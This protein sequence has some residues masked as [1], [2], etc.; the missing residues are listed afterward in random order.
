MSALLAPAGRVDRYAGLSDRLGPARLTRIENPDLLNIE[1]SEGALERRY[2]F[3]REHDNM[4]RV[5]STRLNGVNNYVRIPHHPTYVSTGKALYVGLLVVIREIPTVTTTVWS[6]GFGIGAGLQFALRINPT[7]GA[8]GVL[9]WECLV[10]NGGATTTFAVDETQPN[11]AP[12]GRHRFLQF[13]STNGL[14]S[15]SEFAF[16][17]EAGNKST[18]LTT[19]AIGGVFNSPDDLFL[20]VDCPTTANIAGGNFA[21]VT[22]A[23]AR[24]AYYT[25]LSEINNGVFTI[26]HTAGSGTGL[27]QLI[28]SREL[29]PAE[30]LLCE[31]YWKL[32]DADT[33]NKF[34]D[35]TATNN[36][37]YAPDSAYAWTQDQGLVLGQ[38][39]IRFLGGNSWLHL[40]DGSAGT[41]ILNGVF[42][43]ALPNNARWTVRFIYAPELAPNETSA[44]D[45]C[46]LWAGTGTTLPTP[47]GIRVVSDRF[48]LIYNDGTTPITL[49]LNGAGDPLVSSLANKK[50]RIAAIKSATGT[51]II[52]L[53]I[54]YYSG[55]FGVPLGYTVKN[56]SAACA[57]NTS[58][59]SPD[60]AIGRHCTSFTTQTT[61]IFGTFHTDGSVYGVIDDFQIVY[62]NSLT[63][64]IG[65]GP[66]SNAAFS[67]VS[68]WSSVSPTHT[69]VAYLMMNEGG[70]SQALVASPASTW[71]AYLHPQHASG[72]RWD[73]GLVDPYDSEEAG[74]LFDYAKVL[75]NGDI[76]RQTMAISGSTLYRIDREN[77]EAIPVAG[78]LYKGN[79]PWT[80][81]RYS[82]R[83]FFA[84]PNGQRPVQ[85]DG[86]ALDGLGIAAPL[87]PPAVVTNAVGGTFVAGT[88][89]VYYTF[90][91]SKTGDESN[92]S[93]PTQIVMTG[94]TSKIDSVALSI[95]P[96]PQ[97]NQR[98]IYVSLIGGLPGSAA[99]LATNGTID[100]N[101]TT[102][103]TT[104]IVAAPTT[105]I[106][107]EHFLHEEAPQASIVGVYKDFLFLGG[108]QLYPTRVYRNSIAGSLSYFDQSEV[109]IDLNLNTGDPVVG[110]F[111]QFNR[112]VV[113]LRD[114]FASLFLT[115]DVTD[116]VHFDYVSMS[117]GPVGPKAAVNF[118]DE[119]FY[120]GEQDFWRSNT[121]GEENIST[122]DNPLYPSIQRTIRDR[123]DS[124]RRRRTSLAGHRGRNQIYMACTFEGH[125]NDTTLIYDRTNRIWSKYNL[126]VDILAEVEDENDR[127]WIHGIIHGF[128]CRL[129]TGE[130]DGVDDL[131]NRTGL[132]SAGSP[133]SLS[134]PTPI[135]TTDY[136]G[137]YCWILHVTT[138]EIIQARI[139]NNTTTQLAF[140][141]ALP[142]TVANGDIF[143]IGVVPMFADFMFD[144]EDPLSLKRL[145]WFRANGVSNHD[146]NILRVTYKW[147]PQNR[148]WVYTGAMEATIFWLMEESN[149]I[150]PIGGAGYTLRVRVSESGLGVPPATLTPIAMATGRIKIFEFSMDA[151]L[152]SIPVK[153]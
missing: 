75:D 102:N 133:V 64:F 142:F 9:R 42:N 124:M 103:W 40:R 28:G 44:R 101:I 105:G 122:P 92:P 62:T 13:Y 95:S 87:A 2:G 1:F 107:L 147:G 51:G 26:V 126:P 18:S 109:Y 56:I 121:F 93:P 67:E 23:E 84:A 120:L 106:A 132:A 7:G 83:M 47:L 88:Y 130:Y 21:N 10:R 145:N 5:A 78:G 11:P 34:A 74:D 136:K 146:A 16:F 38:A 135:F 41:S 152:L 91:N 151:D 57:T 43:A 96:D 32:N 31:G 128:V 6:K 46:L 123:I 134:V 72:H 60:W 27:G 25:N 22:L 8:G 140:Y 97:V 54:A 143:G 141:E 144:F 49:T 29:R 61:G 55:A 99:F 149:V 85:W 59:T 90:R 53:Q 30:I 69:V 100:D 139:S 81:A 12:K 14:G 37:G 58:P 33:T 117:H 137:L 52:S 76:L 98:R 86:S 48:Q 70:G 45:Q 94:A 112:F 115:G 79:G 89:Q 113:S 118:N 39:G 71:T 104:D 108:N 73:I 82:N 15:P 17:D 138:G 114:G 50:V 4:L 80:H 125:R 119:F 153:H 129:D 127:P 3:T 63:N 77:R 20:G 131:T 19:T 24:L 111:E 36:P 148:D 35:S 66:S 110:M 150:M 116:P 65:V 68:D